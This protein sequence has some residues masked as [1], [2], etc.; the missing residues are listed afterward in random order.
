MSDTGATSVAQNAKRAAFATLFRGFTCT[1][2]CS[3]LAAEL[4]QGTQLGCRLGQLCCSAG[5]LELRAL[6]GNRVVGLLN[7]LQGRSF[8]YVI[9]SQ[10]CVCQH[11]DNT[12]L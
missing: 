4:S 12:A 11:G 1:P 3:L 5:I 6:V 10:C 7:R 8:V 2:Q 9:G